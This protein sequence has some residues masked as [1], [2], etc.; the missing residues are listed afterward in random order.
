ME[1]IIR[2]QGYSGLS[3]SEALDRLIKSGPNRVVRPREVTFLSIAKEEIMEPMIL[4]LLAVGFFY[5]IF[6]GF[7][8]ALTLY[9]IIVTLVLVE[10]ANEYR[11][12]KA[13]S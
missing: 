10:I 1:G 7:G 9:L 2:N 4:L 6:G 12:K 3:A 5:T 8:D 13:I 11:A